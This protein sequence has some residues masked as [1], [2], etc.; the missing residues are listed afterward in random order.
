MSATARKLIGVLSWLLA[1]GF[2]AGALSST[3]SQIGTV[4]RLIRGTWFGLIGKPQSP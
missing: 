4:A 1:A 2:I 3:D